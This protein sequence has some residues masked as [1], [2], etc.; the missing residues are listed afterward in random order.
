MRERD[1]MSLIEVM[2]AI[3]VLAVGVLGVAGFQTS[4]LSTNRQAQT[5]NQLTRL[6]TTEMEVRRQTLVDVAGTTTCLTRVPHGFDQ[7]DC[8]VEIVSCG[9]IVAQ[10]ASEF[11]CG[12]GLPFATFSVTVSASGRGQT[13]QLRS[14]YGGFYVSGSLGAS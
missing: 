2:I 3:V 13:V 4:T 10:H 8:R 12:T 11:L 1:G 6:A 7:A 5:I 9:V 14:L